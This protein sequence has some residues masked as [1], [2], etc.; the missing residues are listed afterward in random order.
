MADTYTFEI[1]DQLYR[2]GAKHPINFMTGKFDLFRGKVMI[3]SDLRNATQEVIDR[4]EM[5]YNL[6]EYA[7]LSVGDMA[8]NEKMG[9]DG[10]PYSFYE[11]LQRKAKCFY[12]IQ[13]NHDLPELFNSNDELNGEVFDSAF[14]GRIGGVDGIISNRKHPYKMKERDYL[15]VLAIHMTPKYIPE[16]KGDQNVWDVI[17]Q[18]VVIFGHCHHREA[19]HYDAKSGIH[20]FNVDGRVIN[21]N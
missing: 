18:K 3:M 9:G 17:R 1:S 16:V 14:F 7:I 4:L 5:N 8:G 13:G 10:I 20:L 12:Y 6:K 21:I 15:D 11:Q 19:Y 2:E